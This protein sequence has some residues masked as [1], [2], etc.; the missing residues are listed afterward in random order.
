MLTEVAGRYR[1]GQAPGLGEG[2]AQE[3]AGVLA[4][5]GFVLAYTVSF[6]TG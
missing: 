1:G 5:L 2:C 6:Y 4:C 3:N